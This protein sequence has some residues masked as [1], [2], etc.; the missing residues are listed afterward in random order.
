MAEAI[1]QWLGDNLPA[2][3]SILIEGFPRN[4]AQCH[5]L[6]EVLASHGLSVDAF[7]YLDVDDRIA[8]SR[9]TGRLVCPRCETWVEDP[10]PVAGAPCE[11]CG[12]DRVQRRDDAPDVMRDR[13]A[14]HRR[15]APDVRAHY[16][17]RGVLRDLSGAGSRE[18]VAR[19]LFAELAAV[20]RGQW[21]PR[22][23]AAPH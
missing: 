6:D 12:G 19:Q 14:H 4:G 10:I 23:Q 11:R 8:L 15:G 16:A 5:V 18:D 17:G 20:N 22:N 1:S 3:S 7:L 13:L 21:S 2:A 9:V